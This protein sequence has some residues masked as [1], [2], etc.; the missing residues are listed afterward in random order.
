MNYLTHQLLNSEEL[1]TVRKNL[2]KEDF[3]WEDG[4][5][6][7]GK[8]AAKLK[9]NF[10]YFG[11]PSLYKQHNWEEFLWE[12]KPFGFHIR[13]FNKKNRIVSK[14]LEL[15]DLVINIIDNNK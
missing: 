6:T 7:A 8:H 15:V 9:N 3:L 12:G 13:R 2:N 4:K 11:L 10:E 14:E 5:K 1:E